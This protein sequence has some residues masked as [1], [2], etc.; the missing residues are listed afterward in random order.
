MFHTNKIDH[1][2]YFHSFYFNLVQKSRVVKKIS[3]IDE[4]DCELLII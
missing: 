3:L 1:F 4:P 2:D